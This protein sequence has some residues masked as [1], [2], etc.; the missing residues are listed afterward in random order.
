MLL[1]LGISVRIAVKIR[2]Y[3]N[4]LNIQLIYTE[5][6]HIKEEKKKK[7]SPLKNFA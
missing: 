3:N 7:S 2:Y 6:I 4:Y 1:I 5:L